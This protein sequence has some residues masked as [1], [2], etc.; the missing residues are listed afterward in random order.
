M[1]IRENGESIDSRPKRLHRE[2][3]ERSEPV[4]SAKHH[5]DANGGWRETVTGHSATNGEAGESDD[6]Q[7]TVGY[8]VKLGYKIIED[9]ILKGQKI[10]E[11][12]H[13]NSPEEKDEDE[14]PRVL[15]RLLN[16][17]RDLGSVYMDATESI[18]SRLA[19]LAMDYEPGADKK[20]ES[21]PSMRTPDIPVTVS[22]V[23]KI[24]IQLDLKPQVGG[25]L[26]VQALHGLDT[27]ATPLTNIYFTPGTATIS[28]ELH[29]EIPDDCIATAYTGVVVDADTNEPMGTLCVHVVD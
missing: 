10:A 20:S 11:Q 24:R 29:I 7:D 9:Q 4:R 5:V 17:Y 15:G 19:N 23:K 6:G 2:E 28:P 25:N 1:T 12:W 16:V 22:S 18:I 13:A 14:W 21:A 26:R 27:A 8:G 3:P